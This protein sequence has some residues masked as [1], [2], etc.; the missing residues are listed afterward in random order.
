MKKIIT[1]CLFAFAMLLGAP[2]LSA[3]NKLQINQ[4]ASEKAKELKKTLK[5]DNIQQ[6]EVYQAFQEYEKVYQRISSD[7]ENNKELKQKIDL[8][9]A[10][11]MKKILNEEQYTRYKELYNVEDEE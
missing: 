1:L 11:K 2:Q 5:F 6:E 3:Q 8:V 4:A 7:M 9:L 10:Q